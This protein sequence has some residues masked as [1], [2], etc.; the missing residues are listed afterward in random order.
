MEK[1]RSPSPPSPSSFADPRIHQLVVLGMLLIYGTLALDFEI[2]PVNVAII[3]P[4]ALAVQWLLGRWVGLTRFDPKSPLISS[5]SLT[6][7]LRTTDPG[8]AALAAVVTIA[9]KFV[10]RWRGRHFFN[11][12]NF[13][14][15]MVLLFTEGAWV[16]PGQWGSTALLAFFLVGMGSL[17]IRR[18]ERSEVTLGFL[19]AWSVVLFGRAA[20]LGDPWQIPLHQLA[21]GA[22]LVFAFFMISDPKTTP[23]RRSGRLLHVVVV[24]GVAAFIRFSLYEPNELLWALMLCA[25]LVPLID[26]WL[27]GRP[28]RWT[29]TRPRLSSSHFTLRPFDHEPKGAIP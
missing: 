7:L 11:P 5:L 19:A 8:L 9:S 24:A 2:R 27:P 1:P 13:G 14:L 22:L 20:W 15:C 12:T 28:Y 4:T 6:L 26:H 23:A 18:A 16:S 10:F 3:V 29:T 17:V 25:P 21:N